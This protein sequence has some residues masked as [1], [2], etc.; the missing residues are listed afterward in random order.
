[1]NKLEEYSTAGPYEKN[2]ACARFS[3]EEASGRYVLTDVTKAGNTYTLSFWVKAE[4]DS[5]IYVGGETVEVTTSWKKHRIVIT[6]NDANLSLVFAKAGVYLLYR[7]KLE[8]GN[9]PTDWSPA[10]GDYSTTEQMKSEIKLQIGSI[11][12]SVE[13]SANGYAVIKLAT[14]EGSTQEKN[15]PDV[16]K[17]FA[18]S[19]SSAEISA[20]KI[21]FNAGTLIINSNNLQLDANGNVSMT[22][23]VNANAGEIGGCK[24]IDGKLTISSGATIA[25]WNIDSNSI[26][27]YSS[28]SSWEKGTFMCTGSTYAY[29]IGGSPSLKN[30][31][32]GAGGKFG[33]TKDGT[34]YASD[35]NITG[36]T[37]K[38]K[39]TYTYLG[40]TI[41]AGYVTVNSGGLAVTSLDYEEG[42]SGAA[43]MYGTDIIQYACNGNGSVLL[44]Q[45]KQGEDGNVSEK[46]LCGPW[47][48]EALTSPTQVT[49]D[50]NAKLEINPQADVYSHIFDKLQPVTFKYKNGTSGRIHTGFIAQNVEDAVLSLGLTTQEFAGVCYDLDEN[51]N[52]VKYGIRYEE[53]VSLNTYEI[54]KLKK[55][56]ADLE[57][58]LSA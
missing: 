19:D 57:K 9:K 50:R 45:V 31:V 18:D 49:S 48:I 24:I 21:A 10:P 52:K 33:V 15:L 30:W 27:K 25:G 14:G 34:V 4:A 29:S 51:G 22:G 26:Y 12:L 55:R 46:V 2:E 20:G 11:T 13:D 7:L 43:M 5:T 37:I 39:H 41:D 16:R 3:I 56:V 1:M 32:F 35:L 54:Q 8:E 42:E 44:I 38:I 40:Q 17:M 23:T 53:I 47:T 6:A 58:K 36:G 28:G